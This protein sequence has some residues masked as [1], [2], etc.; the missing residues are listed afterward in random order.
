MEKPLQQMDKNL[1]QTD[2]NLRLKTDMG[3][4]KAKLNDQ[5]SQLTSVTNQSVE[6]KLIAERLET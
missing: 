4:Q 5:V 3:L 6:A 2:I 1:N